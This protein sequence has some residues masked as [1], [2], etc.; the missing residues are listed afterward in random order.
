MKAYPLIYSRTQKAD[1]VP[2]FLVRPA[3]F[4]YQK[5]LNYVK[6][7]MTNL[8][9]S[10]VIRYCTFSVGTYHI[11]GGISCI[12]NLAAGISENPL[13]HAEIQETADRV[14]PLFQ[15]LITASIVNIA[16]Q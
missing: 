11:C 16:N 9:I 3:D 8:D 12:S 7:A 1:F 13:T 4:D 15:Q 14:A 2:D 5:A 6:N 10:N